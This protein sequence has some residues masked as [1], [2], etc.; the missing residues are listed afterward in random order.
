LPP[1][2]PRVL[3]PRAQGVAPFLVFLPGSADPMV[4]VSLCRAITGSLAA[5]VEVEGQRHASACHCGIALAPRDGSTAEDLLRSAERALAAAREQDTPGYGFFDPVVSAAAVRRRDVERAVAAAHQSQSLRL[6]YQ[7]IHQMRSGELAGFEALMRLDDTDLGPMSALG[8]HSGGRTGGIDQP[9]S[10]HGRWMRPA[11]TRPCGPRISS[12]P[13]TSRRRNSSPARSCRPCARRSKNMALPAYRLEV[14]ITEGTLMKD[15]ELVLG[16]LRVL[17]EMGVGVALDDFGTGYSSLSYLWRFP[18]SKLKIDRSFVAALD[19]SA[20]AK[21][22]LRSIA[23]LG[24][25]LGMTVTAEGIENP[26]QLASL[27]TLGC[28]LAQGY[29][30]G[31]ALPACRTRR[32]HHAQFRVPPGPQDARARAPRRHGNRLISTFP[33]AAQRSSFRRDA[34]P[35]SDIMRKLSPLKAVLHA[36]NSVWSFRNM[37][38]RIGMLWVPIMLIAGLVEHF[39]GRPDPRSQEMTPQALVQVVTG[40]ISIIAVCSIAVSWHRFILRDELGRW[41]GWTVTSSA[42]PATRC[43]SCS[44]CSRP[45][46]FFLTVA[47]LAPGAWLLPRHAPSCWRAASSPACRSSFPPSRSATRLQLP[48]RME[49]REGNFWQVLGVFLLSAAIFFGIPFAHHGDEPHR[50]RSAQL[51]LSSWASSPAP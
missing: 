10:A 43:S 35:R 39:T 48:G 1:S 5:G 32:H 19:Q 37:A 18:F 20:S 13:S 8:I 17:R 4:V 30:L 22:I 36:L 26:R 15:S 49:A 40:I 7:P 28:D 42:M 3:S 11:A 46:C 27:R 38:L 34:N 33:S 29:L 51:R 50:P 44:W 25:G 31:Q 2:S 9:T 47:M 45:R 23:K 14:E 16:Q 21:G 41:S 12:W 6:V 24:H